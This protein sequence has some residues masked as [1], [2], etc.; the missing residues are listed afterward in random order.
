MQKADTEKNSTYSYMKMKYESI[1]KALDYYKV[2]E[3]K[4]QKFK[5]EEKA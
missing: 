1:S 2:V 3:E 5:E 4:I